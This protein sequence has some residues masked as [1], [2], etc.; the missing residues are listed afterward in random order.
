MIKFEDLVIGNAAG[1]VKSLDDVKRFCRSSATRITVGSVTK[2]ERVGNIAVSPGGVYY[3]DP[4]LR[5]SGNSLGLPNMGMHKYSHVLPQMVELAHKAGKQLWVSIVGETIEEVVEL[6]MFV[7]S[8]G[9]DGVEINLACPNVHDRGTQKKLMC[10]DSETVH[11]ILQQVGKLRIKG[12]GIGVKIAPTRD[13]STLDDLALAVNT[14]DIVTEVVATN[15]RGGQRFIVDGVDMIAF[16]PPG[17]DTVVNTGGEAGAPLHEDAVW[18]ASTMRHYLHDRIEINGVGGIF[19]GGE[20]YDFIKEGCTR[21]Q[22]ATAI[23]EHK[24]GEAMLY[25]IAEELHEHMPIAA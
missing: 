18:V 14:S 7:L 24:P 17:S 3:Y 20:A 25:N 8:H 11:R 15:T 2:R 22:C 21:I 10:D 13:E 9:A 16:K 19:T 4:V 23:M 1:M 12:R 6:V 5:R